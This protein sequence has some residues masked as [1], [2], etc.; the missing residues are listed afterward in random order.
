MLIGPKEGRLD[1]VV[2]G[3]RG[4][5]EPPDVAAQCSMA[6]GKEPEPLFVA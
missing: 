6:L 2:G 5:H 4:G 3:G 1:D